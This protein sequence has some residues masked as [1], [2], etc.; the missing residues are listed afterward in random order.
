MSPLE[1]EKK[2]DMHG[3]V[4]LYTQ[5][6]WSLVVPQATGTAADRFGTT[7]PP[8]FPTNPRLSSKLN[9]VCV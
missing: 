1:M 7:T 6:A 4:C 2:K 5:S 3:L 8:P 9:H